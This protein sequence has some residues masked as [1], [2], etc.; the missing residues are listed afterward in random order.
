MLDEDVIVMSNES[1][2]RCQRAYE[3]LLRDVQKDKTRILIVHVFA[4]HGAQVEG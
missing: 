3:K 4:G 1:Y 2:E